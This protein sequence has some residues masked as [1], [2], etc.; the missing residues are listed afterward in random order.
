MALG[1]LVWEYV[2]RNLVCNFHQP[3]SSMSKS[4]KKK[5]KLFE[6][7]SYLEELASILLDIN[8]LTPKKGEAYV[9][10][11]R[12]DLSVM[13][14]AMFRFNPSKEYAHIDG[15]VEIQLYLDASGS[16]GVVVSNT[17]RDIVFIRHSGQ[18]KSLRMPMR[19]HVLRQE[20]L[21][22]EAEEYMLK[23]LLPLIK[24]RYKDVWT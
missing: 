20:S 24:T 13:P 17:A 2:A 10:D 12:I 22:R 1:V 14:Q 3:F 7:G 18:H 19:T 4:P 15:H 5:K 21:L 16:D 8:T 9:S 6:D 23:V 11:L